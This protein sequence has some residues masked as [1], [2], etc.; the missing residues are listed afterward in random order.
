MPEYEFNVHK[1]P[2]DKMRDIGF[3]DYNPEHW[4]FVK[5]LADSITF[6]L[7]IAKANPSRKGWRIDVLD[8]NFLQPYDYQYYL[9][10][11]PNHPFAKMID[12]RVKDI[13]SE[14]QEKGIVEGYERG[15]YI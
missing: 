11:E 5:R 14:L 10:E 12:E 4:Y 15:M 1:L 8:E 13:M 9:S 2:E 3:T 6:N 7:T